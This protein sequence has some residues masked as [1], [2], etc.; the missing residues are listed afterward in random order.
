MTLEFD[1]NRAPYTFGEATAAARKAAGL[2]LSAEDTTRTAWRRYAEAERDYRRSLALEIARLRGEGV[3]A[4]IAADLA[5][6][7]ERV[8]ELRHARDIA[9]GVVEAAKQAGWRLQADRR[10]LHEFISW[11]ARRDLA[12]GYGRMP[13]PRYESVN[14]ERVS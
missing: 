7:E 11:S 12:E 3:A 10:D 5:R 4:T 14:S 9:E 6:G 8:S 1:P 2:Q 13:E